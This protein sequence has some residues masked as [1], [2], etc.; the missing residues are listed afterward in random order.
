MATL[1]ATFQSSYIFLACEATHQGG[2]RDGADRPQS[3]L[4]DVIA[5]AAN[6]AHARERVEKLLVENLYGSF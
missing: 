3:V 5:F 1:P 4:H 2:P 6:F